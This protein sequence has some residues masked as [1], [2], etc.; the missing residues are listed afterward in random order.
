MRIKTLM[1]A[2]CGVMIATLVATAQLQ[3]PLR[4]LK[5]GTVHQDEEVTPA[6][7]QLIQ[8][9]EGP[10]LFRA[11]CASCHGSDAR[12]NGPTASALK[13][14]PADLTRISERNG[15]MFPFMEVEK[16]IS[17]ESRKLTSHGSRE[18]PVWGPIFSQIAWD[19]DLGTLRIYKLTKYLES[20]QKKE[21]P[22]RFPATPLDR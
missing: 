19:Q 2:I 17:G 3:D 10:A 18:M 1:A 8:S 6:E 16:F 7:R 21:F 11:Y 4:E 12:G 13:Y 14:P 15:G 22:S 20:L 9:L 5:Q